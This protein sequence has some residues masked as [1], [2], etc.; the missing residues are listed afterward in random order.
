VARNVQIHRI[1]V[2]PIDAQRFVG[3][4]SIYTNTIELDSYSVDLQ[5]GAVRGK[6]RLDYSAA[7]MPAQASAQIRGVDLARVVKRAAPTARRI[8]GTLDADLLVA[9]AFAWTPRPR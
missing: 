9:T 2:A 1:V 5:G 7:R 6:G 4:V 3:A 8:T